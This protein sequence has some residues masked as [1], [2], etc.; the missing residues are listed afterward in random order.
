MKI[1]QFPSEKLLQFWKLMVS[2]WYL[3][4]SGVFTSEV[5]LRVVHPC[6]HHLSHWGLKS[7]GV[8]KMCPKCFRTEDT[9][10]LRDECKHVRLWRRFFSV[11]VCVECFSPTTNVLL[12]GPLN[13][14]T[15]CCLVSASIKCW[16]VNSGLKQGREWQGGSSGM[17]KGWQK[18]YIFKTKYSMENPDSGCRWHFSLFLTLHFSSL[19]IITPLFPTPCR[20][21]NNRTSRNSPQTGCATYFCTLP[22]STT[23][24]LCR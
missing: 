24:S 20:W 19:Y 5:V 10:G 2:F 13:S 21:T 17:D 9:D 14:P 3:T 15:A 16:M 18:I 12:C 8:Y 23:N 1:F 11:S 7:Q 6:C 4:S 22:P